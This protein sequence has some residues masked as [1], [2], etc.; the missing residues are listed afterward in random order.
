MVRRAN[1]FDVM[2]F[3]G[4]DATHQSVVFPSPSLGHTRRANHC[5]KP[6]QARETDTDTDSHPRY[7]NLTFTPPNPLSALARF[8]LD[9]SAAVHTRPQPI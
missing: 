1:S 7:H 5:A 4:D 6:R 2:T 9:M 3:R 8:N